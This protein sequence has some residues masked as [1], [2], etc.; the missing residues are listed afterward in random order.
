MTQFPEMNRPHVRAWVA[1]IAFILIGAL[2]SVAQDRNST[3][4]PDEDSPA[5]R[6]TTR[7]VNSLRAARKL[8]L[9]GEYP[10][11]IAMY[12]A[13]SGNPRLHLRAA[14]GRAEID[15]QI[16]DY[17]AGLT[18]LLGLEEI[19]GKSAAWN[20]TVAALKEEVGDYDAAISHNEKAIAADEDNLRARYQLGR[21]LETIG[22]IDQA[23]DAYRYFND[24]MA[25]EA[26][27]ERA[28]E[29][30][31]LGLGFLRFSTLTRHRDIVRRTRHVLTEV[32]QEAMEFVDADYWPARLASAELLLAKHNL[33]EA[34][35][36]FEAILKLNSNVA[37]VHVGLGR[38][39]LEEW[40]F[41]EVDKCVAR[42]LK[43]NPSSVVARVLEADCRMTERKYEDAIVAADHALATNPNSIDA[44]GV[45]AAALTRLGNEGGA[46]AV[47]AAVEKL[48]E[49]AG[50]L[51][52]ALGTWLAAGRQYGEA[53]AHFKKAIEF[54][55][56]WASPRTSLGQ[57]YMDTG[58]EALAR[59]TLEAS[60]ALDSF[61]SHT[62]NVLELL[63]VID[64]FD[65]LE[66]DHFIIKFDKQ[67]GDRAAADGVI[68]PYVSEY[69]EGIH[70]E[71][72]G[73]FGV[74][75]HIT[76]GKDESNRGA[77][78]EGAWPL[79]KKT[80]IELFPD[81]MGFSV[82]VTGRPFIAT[83]GACSGRVIAMVAPRGMAP[84]G[85]FNWATVLRHE[86]THTVTLAA[87]ENRIPHWMT[88]GL[89]VFEETA[90]RSW[91]TKELLCRAVRMGQRDE[92]SAGGGLFT[93]KS[94]DW[95]FMRP[96]RPDDRQLAY[97]QSEWMFEYIVE[98]HGKRAIGGFLKAFRAGRNQAEAFREVL[99]IE[100]TAFDAEF[101]QWAKLQ[102]GSWGFSVGPLRE[103]EV[104]RGELEMLREGG[105]R[106]EEGG[107][108]RRGAEMDEGTKRRVEAALWGEYAEAQL[109]D[110]EYEQAEA[111]ARR[112]LEAH[113]ESA[114]A[115]EVLC[116]VL[117]GRMLAEK[118][119]GRR[120]EFVN[121]VDPYL[122]TLIRVEPGCGVA[123]K[124]LGFVEQAW[125]QW[126]EATGWLLKYQ[127]RFPDDPDSYRR[128]AGIYLHLGAT[129][130]A[131]G[132]LERL[133]LLSEDEPAVARQV[134][135]IYMERAG[136]AAGEARALSE[137]AATWYRRALEVDPYDGEIHL[138]L[139]EALLG[140]GRAEAAVRE[141][142][143]VCEIWPEKGAGYAGLAR[144]YEAL[145]DLEK[146]RKYRLKSEKG[147][148][149]KDNV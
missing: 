61:D 25:G 9:A 126:K 119:E 48:N 96:R 15:I 102:V 138:G 29:L 63:D 81:H 47:I 139:G 73:D 114:R 11:A 41:E 21:V 75:P 129:D 3:F 98:R 59:R 140:A 113:R 128:L 53:E 32:F 76:D 146:A 27:P 107:E 127:E 148:E 35:Q 44:L 67:R 135:E 74:S 84:F 122:R 89:A 91:G 106:R 42:A 87:T 30:T 133:F 68:A 83:V 8:A 77:D 94:I 86:F 39:A 82:R 104:I 131:L 43:V 65:Q 147:A 55:P 1:A 141:Y 115:L 31:Y 124:Y 109:F 36:D 85:R 144:A 78:A 101:A 93:L 4:G 49:R 12:E 56:W 16:G 80:I 23:I 123:M 110:G 64:R 137:K 143:V 20:A 142:Q 28:D 105:E 121:E 52:N 111:S 57:V 108:E 2:A 70:E 14:C 97:M 66:T 118:D 125:S 7:P 149:K 26:L 132:Q 38:I 37:A 79:G 103:K 22:R 24:R 19:G 34:K 130:S 51:H 17:Q 58:E 5:G 50:V 120:N 72:C 10:A 136:E 145:G 46:K 116:R 117:V 54:A 60:F 112:G 69:L 100:T 99:G 95:G 13:L 134:A 18:R 90:P 88:E 6:P 62:H 33:G 45:K 40:N 71:I 92:V